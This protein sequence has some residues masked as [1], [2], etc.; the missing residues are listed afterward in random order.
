M[1][2]YRPSLP[3]QPRKTQ[4]VVPNNRLSQLN[5]H[6]AIPPRLLRLG[7]GTYQQGEVDD[8]LIR[9]TTRVQHGLGGLVWWVAAFRLD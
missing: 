6:T 7:V 2:S 1:W 3:R 9:G 4:A 5:F 8:D